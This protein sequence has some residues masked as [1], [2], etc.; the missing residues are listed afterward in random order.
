LEKL[1][2]WVLKQNAD[3]EPVASPE[4]VA[5]MQAATDATTLSQ[6]LAEYIRALAVATRSRAELSAGIS[7][8]GAL[9][10]ARVARAAARVNDRDYVT[11]DDITDHFVSV[12]AHRLIPVGGFSG[13]TMPDAEGLA[14]D[15][16]RETPMP[17]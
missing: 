8:R 6:P 1:G 4:D 7:T 9:A 12:A 3:F 17:L 15:V 16:L 13:M 11:T 2:R 14:S 10:V 5:A